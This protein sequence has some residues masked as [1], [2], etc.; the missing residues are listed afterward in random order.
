MTSGVESERRY[1]AVGEWIHFYPLRAHLPFGMTINQT[2]R[3]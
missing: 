3:S 2:V 1:F